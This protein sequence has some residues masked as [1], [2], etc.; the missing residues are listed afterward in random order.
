M[1]SGKTQASIAV[2]G[3]GY[4]GKNLV[5]NFHDLG[6]LHSVCD[7]Q[8]EVAGAMREQYPGIGQVDA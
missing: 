1:T 8:A 4:W 5:R 7:S 6:V 3:T 2:V